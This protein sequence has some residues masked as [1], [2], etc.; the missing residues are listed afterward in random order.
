MNTPQ[1]RATIDKTVESIR[2]Y[3]STD[4]DGP[5]SLVQAAEVARADAARF[6]NEVNDLAN[7]VNGSARITNGEDG[8]PINTIIDPTTG[9]RIQD[10]TKS[11]AFTKEGG[12]RVRAAEAKQKQ[13][14]TNAKALRDKAERDE[15]AAGK[16]TA[17]EATARE[18]A[19]KAQA[20]RQQAARDARAARDA[21][22]ADR[23]E[24]GDFS[25]SGNGDDVGASDGG[26]YGSDAGT[27]GGGDMGVICLT[28]DMKVKRNGV[29]DFVTKVQVGDIVDNTIV[30]EVLHK[31][32]REGYYKINGELKITNDHPVLVNGLWK[33]TEDLVLGDYIN[34]VLVT[35]LEYVEQ[36]T[37]TVY[38]GTAEDRYDVYTEGEVYI[39]HGQYKNALKKAA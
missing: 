12:R 19:N 18:A 4:E 32:M 3:Y 15:I 8:P 34:N 28:E 26:D 33:R 9:Q 27:G 29:I 6:K 25:D 30:T 13:A 35:S 37:P 10:P 24:R 22:R 23:E 16:E 21:A 5:L 20:D 36:V 11:R 17:S 7:P 31:H 2:D 38:I 14:E 1:A 39:V